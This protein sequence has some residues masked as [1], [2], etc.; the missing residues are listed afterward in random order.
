LKFESLKKDDVLRWGEK[1][2]SKV[3]MEMEDY[4][5]LSFLIAATCDPTQIHIAKNDGE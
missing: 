4:I 1:K 2:G 5:F 3:A